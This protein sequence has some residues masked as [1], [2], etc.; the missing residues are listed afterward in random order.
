MENIIKEAIEQKKILEFYYKDELRIVE[1]FVHGISTTGKE[2]L[3][4]FQIG[5]TSSDS[6]SFGW[7]LFSVEKIRSL[8]TK[9]Q[10]YNGIR[11]N[12]NPNDSVMNH[13]YARV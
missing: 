12:Y 13:I 7:K 4:G 9:N 8:E 10:S 2:S 3:R 6:E 1:P 5:G 11:D